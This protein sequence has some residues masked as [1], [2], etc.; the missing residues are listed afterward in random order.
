MRDMDRH[1]HTHIPAD[2]YTDADILIPYCNIPNEEEGNER[3]GHTHT[4]THIPADRY[5]DADIL[6]P[7]CNIPNE[8][9]GSER[10]GQTHTHTH[11]Q[12]DIQMQTYLYHI[13]TYRMKRREVR[14]MDTHTHT[15]TSRQIY[16]AV[17][18]S[19]NYE[20][21]VSQNEYCPLLFL[22]QA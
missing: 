8:E 15:H 3:H 4:H 9:E 10:H 16:T 17:I 20:L 18:R 21:C 6:I 11:Q 1:T 19:C 12:T 22:T 5:T 2:R 14:D 13:V 7:Y